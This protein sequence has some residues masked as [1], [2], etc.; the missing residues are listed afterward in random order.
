MPNLTPNNGLIKP[1]QDEFYDVEVFNKNAD[2]IDS[3]LGRIAKKTTDSETNLFDGATIR[4]SSSKDKWLFVKG[5]GGSISDSDEIKQPIGIAGNGGILL[6]WVNP[7]NPLF[8]H[9]K[10][11]QSDS[12][13]QDPSRGTEI[14]KI[15]DKTVTSHEVTGLTNGKQYYFY[16]VAYDKDGFILSTKE[17]IVSPALDSY[18]PQITDLKVSVAD[19]YVLLTWKN[20]TDT[21]FD[22]VLV[23]RLQGNFPTMNIGVTLLD[24]DSELLADNTNLYNGTEYG[25]CIW[26][27]AKDGSYNKTPLQITATPQGNTYVKPSN[28]KA[29]ADNTKVKLSW[30]AITDTE[31]KEYVLVRTLNNFATSP[32]D[33]NIKIIYQGSDKTTFEDTNLVNGTDYYYKL[34]VY[35]KDMQYWDG[36]EGN[37]KATPQ[38]ITPYGIRVETATNKFT[39]LGS[40]VGLTAQAMSPTV[41]TP[42]ND[43]DNIYPWSE[44]KRVCLDDSGNKIAYHGDPLFPTT[45]NYFNSDKTSTKVADF[46]NYNIF[47]QIPKFYYKEVYDG[48]NYEIW[49]CKNKVDDTY[50]LHPAFYRNRIKLPFQQGKVISS[51]KGSDFGIDNTKS[52]YCCTDLIP[53]EKLTPTTNIIIEGNFLNSTIFY[54]YDENKKLVYSGAPATNALTYHLGLETGV[55]YISVE[56]NCSLIDYFN[57]YNI[58]FSYWYEKDKDP[59]LQEVDYRYVGS[60]MATY[61]WADINTTVRILGTNLG[62]SNTSDTSDTVKMQS[63]PHFDK[64]NKKFTLPV[65]NS[66]FKQF[67]HCAR[68]QGEGFT[69]TDFYLHNAIQM[70]YLVE[71][72]DTNIQKTIGIGMTDC[73]TD[74]EARKFGVGSTEKYG[75]KSFGDLTKCSNVSYRGIENLYGAYEEYLD[76][77]AISNGFSLDIRTH[78]N[79][80]KYGMLFDTTIANVMSDETLYS[81]KVFN[82]NGLQYGLN[83]AYYGFPIKNSNMIQRGFLPD[84]SV[85][86]T[87]TTGYTDTLLFQSNA[88]PLPLLVGGRGYEQN[89]CGLFNYNTNATSNWGTARLAY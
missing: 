84:M 56:L 14:I 22:K 25:Y 68:N 52:G 4:Y 11:F 36:V 47:T 27:F 73:N 18:I 82:L 20:P 62:S 40:A 12:T 67:K 77:C 43:F 78:I 88:N 17:I 23:R 28:L 51:V 50:K 44:M 55:K 19:K 71:Y 33:T 54:Y 26:A 6:Q 49:I 41:T 53:F 45:D 80:N 72:A 70:L 34:F 63:I 60:Y 66:S 9:I 75:N 8:D 42:K 79:N 65:T 39:R 10:I 7:T 46:K 57:R 1:L 5:G 61:L 16:I 76:G 2:I 86:F 29:T 21:R 89:E 31:F 48:E 37:V 15:T 74:Y 64:V 58:S 81:Y 30:D 69:I 83:K 35:K 38:E 32:V 3:Q 13:L 87:S 59:N 85:K 24:S